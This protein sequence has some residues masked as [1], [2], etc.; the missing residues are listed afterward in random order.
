MPTVTVQGEKAFEVDSGK[1]LVLAIEDA[2]ID[3]L[4]RCGGNARCTTGPRDRPRA[5]YPA[6]LPD[7]RRVGSGGPGPQ[8]GASP[9]DAARTAPHGLRRFPGLP[10]FTAGRR[11]TYL[12]F[13]R[14]AH[15]LHRAARRRTCAPH[16]EQRW[17]FV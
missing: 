13:C 15:R 16:Q 12:R 1:K 14:S 17:N 2:G 7:P 3:I 11:S 5:E 10:A 4:H 9:G 6:L 8:P